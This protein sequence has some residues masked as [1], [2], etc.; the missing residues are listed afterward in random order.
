MRSSTRFSGASEAR[1]WLSFGAIPSHSSRI[2]WWSG[3]LRDLNPGC[4]VAVVGREP[5][6][7]LS[8]RGRSAIA[9]II[10]G[11]RWHFG[12]MIAPR[13]S[14]RLLATY[15]EQQLYGTTVSLAPHHFGA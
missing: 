6:P 10:P 13:A 8:R 5:L 1:G 3:R 14:R 4:S 2:A 15:G 7:P 12:L 9:H 11:A